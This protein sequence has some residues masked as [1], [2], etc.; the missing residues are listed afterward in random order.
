VRQLREDNQQLAKQVQSARSEAQTAQAAAQGAQAQAAELAEAEIQRLANANQQADYKARINAIV[1]ANGGLATA[2]G[3]AAA[4]C[5]N[6][7]RQI[8][9]AK[10]QWALENRKSADAI[11]TP[12]DL[13]KFIRSGI[14]PTCPAGGVYT[15]NAVRADPTCSIPGHA[16]PPP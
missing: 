7:L 3:Q 4:A 1:D 13:A 15:L 6:N 9:G 11:P 2:Q 14:L 10:Q 8:D 16:L 12:Q 5:I